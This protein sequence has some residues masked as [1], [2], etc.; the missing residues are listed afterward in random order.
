[1]GLILCLFIL[2]FASS[3]IG[4]DLGVILTPPPGSLGKGDHPQFGRALGLSG[5]VLAIGAPYAHEAGGAVFLY[6]GDF[7]NPKLVKVLRHDRDAI[8]GFAL[9]LRGNRLAVAALN[10]KDRK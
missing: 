4:G 10:T 8:F 6:C 3:A 9:A 7:N 5:R 2:L 1:M